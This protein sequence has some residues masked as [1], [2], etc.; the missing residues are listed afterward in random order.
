MVNFVDE[1]CDSVSVKSIPFKEC[2]LRRDRRG[3]PIPLT[4]ADAVC[5]TDKIPIRNVR[6][7]AK[8]VEAMETQTEDISAKEVR[9]E[10]PDVNGW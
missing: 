5:Q 9:M 1:Q 6:I 8:E 10:G 7:L 4:N 2:R 3:Q